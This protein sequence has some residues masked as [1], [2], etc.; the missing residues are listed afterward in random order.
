MTST[1]MMRYQR[2][3]ARAAQEKMERQQMAKVAVLIIGMLLAFGL[4]GAVDYHD[5]TMDLSGH[6]ATTERW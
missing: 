1:Q 2:R 4:A 5:R 3:A 6:V